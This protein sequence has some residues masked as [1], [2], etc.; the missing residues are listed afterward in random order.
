MKVLCRENTP[1]IT[2]VVQ[3]SMQVVFVA[4]GKEVHGI[5][6]RIGRPRRDISEQDASLVG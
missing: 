1:L 6:P 2:A 4:H 5:A 3:V